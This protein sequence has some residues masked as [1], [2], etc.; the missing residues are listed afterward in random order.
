MIGHRDTLI[1]AVCAA[2][3]ACGAPSFPPSSPP[4][5]P[6]ADPNRV[7]LSPDIVSPSHGGL[8]QPTYRL[9]KSDEEWQAL[10]SESESPRLRQYGEAS[11]QRAPEI[12][13]NEHSLL[14]AAIGHRPSGCCSVEFGSIDEGPERMTV[15]VRIKEAGRGCL[16][17]LEETHPVAI[18]MLPRTTKQADFKIV[19]EIQK[20]D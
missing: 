18:A 13:F 11:A 19:R 12:D 15:T 10:W 5:T 17:L 1:V 8:A 7:L 14:V 2:L 16:I 6:Q 3:A 20:C 9:L 4:P